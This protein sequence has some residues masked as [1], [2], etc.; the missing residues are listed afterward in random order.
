MEAEA[1][2]LEIQA[3]L[4]NQASAAIRFVPRKCNVIAHNL[5]NVALEF[6][7]AV[8]WIGDF[9]VQWELGMESAEL[10]V[11]EGPK[12]LEKFLR[13]QRFQRQ[14][15]Q[16]SVWLNIVKPDQIKEISTKINDF[17]K[18]NSDP[19]ARLLALALVSHEVTSWLVPSE[20]NKR[21]KEIDKQ[22]RAS[23]MGIIKNRE[24][25]MKA[26]EAG[27]DDLAY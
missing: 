22:I 5:A 13:Q 15:L 1:V 11:A 14:F 10:G 19:L 17:Q 27:N 20:R 26:E 21:M 25:A 16:A 12:K 2:L 18:I 3:E 8:T 23:L 6:E 7:E 4:K 9:P 24:K